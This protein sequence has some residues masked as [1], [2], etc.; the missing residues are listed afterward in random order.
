MT[1]SV[2]G[3]AGL[4]SWPLAV[5]V[6]VVLAVPYLVAAA[7]LGAHSGRR[8]APHRTA[9]WVAGALVL[10]LAVSPLVGTL[11]GGAAR[12]HMLQHV[13]L[14]MAGPLALVLG[15]PVTLVLASL[16]VRRRRLAT[17]ALRTRPVRVLA[18]PVTAAALHV[19][20]L[21]A[22]Y[23]TP[24]YALTLTDGRVD[25]LVLLH[26]V[27]AGSVFV[28]SLVGPE[29]AAHGPR[30][31]VRVAVLVLA[32]AAHGYLAKLLYAR[33]PDLPPGGGHGVVEM[34]DAAQWMYYAGDVVEVA[35]A[36]ALFAVWYR[37]AGRRTRAG[38]A[39]PRRDPAQPAEYPAA[40]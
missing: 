5:A 1:H 17:A 28:W 34:R 31:G 9:A 8:W 25:G 39:R 6:L 26:F 13:L 35:L 4:A 33:T 29:R 32:S 18:H 11:A 21:Y 20:G 23:L 40:V 14:G 38:R 27:L 36:V 22:L 37:R 10:A 15:A 2:H 3:H 7:R 30:L 16:A 24:L 19:G 12:G